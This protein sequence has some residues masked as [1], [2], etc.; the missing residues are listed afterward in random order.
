MGTFLTR[1][2]YNTNW[3]LWID[4]GMYSFL[5]QWVAKEESV[6]CREKAAEQGKDLSV[7]RSFSSCHDST[8]FIGNRKQK[9]TGALKLR[10]S[11]KG[12]RPL[13]D[14]LCAHKVQWDVLILQKTFPLCEENSVLHLQ[15]H[16]CLF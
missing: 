10:Q 3:T 15:L 4:T 8:V 5:D 16:F 6:F 11:V 7:V 12:G 14:P 2:E 1:T 13:S 9:I